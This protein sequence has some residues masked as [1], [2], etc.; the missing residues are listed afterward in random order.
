MIW[1]TLSGISPKIVLTTPGPS[2]TSFLNL[3]SISVFQLFSVSTFQLFS[4]SV[5]GVLGTGTPHNPLA[6]HALHAY[7]ELTIWK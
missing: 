2:G 3:V 1:R 5:F 4:I 6:L 7:L